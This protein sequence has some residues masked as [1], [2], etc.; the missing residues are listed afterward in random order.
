[1]LAGIDILPDGRRRAAL[2]NAT[3]TMFAQDFGGRILPFDSSA[4]S[5]YAEIFAARKRAGRPIAPHD[6]MIAV[7]ARTHGAGMVTRNTADF[8]GCGLILINPWDA[9]D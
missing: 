7:I 5:A 3:R 2:G 6:L 8:E 1:M 9:Q 4:S